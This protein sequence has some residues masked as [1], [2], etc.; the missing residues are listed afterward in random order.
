MET[1]HLTEIQGDSHFK[2]GVLNAVIFYL[3]YLLKC[4]MFELIK[5]DFFCMWL[6]KTQTAAILKKII[7][8]S[9]LYEDVSFY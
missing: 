6:D 5:A 2:M 1:K 9:Q 8:L 4:F 7:W 3:K